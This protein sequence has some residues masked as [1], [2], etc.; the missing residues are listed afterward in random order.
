MR[1]VND[2]LLR[3]VISKRSSILVEAPIH[4]GEGARFSAPGSASHLKMRFSAGESTALA[5][6][7][8]R[9]VPLTSH[10][11][12]RILA[13]NQRQMPILGAKA[14][15]QWAAV[16]IQPWSLPT[17]SDRPTTASQAVCAM[18]VPPCAPP[19]APSTGDPTSARSP[20][21][22]SA[23][24]RTNSSGKRTGPIQN[25]VS[26]EHDR[27]FQRA[28]ANQPHR[29][30]AFKIAHESKSPRRGQFAAKTIAID[31]NLNF[32]PPHFRVRVIHE[33]THHK[34]VMRVNPNPPIAFRDLQRLH[35]FQISS[36]PA[37]PAQ[38]GA[39]QH[40]G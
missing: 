33:T 21:R 9:L 3:Q 24:C 5:L 12:M 27:I 26:R 23:L 15:R 25:I 7:A 35:D 22:S 39:I 19:R 16:R 36:P 8:D 2:G 17:G 37:Q 4:A 20:I 32:L 40:V 34:I 13:I 18:H 29:P 14:S 38:S 11:E 28:P 10:P 30:Q 6:E 31:A 1:F